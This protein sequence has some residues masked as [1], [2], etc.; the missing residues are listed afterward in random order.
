MQYRKIGQQDASIVAFGAWAI[1]GWMWGG[2]DEDDA[3]DAIHAAL[4]V[5]MN[6]IDTAPI[7]GFG[8]SEQVIGRAL[9]DKR[10]QAFI[11]TKCGMVWG[12]EFADKG[13]FKFNSDDQ[14]INPEGSTE[15]RIY[16]DP[17]S[18][19]RELEMSLDRLKTDYVDLYQTHWQESTTPIADT[20]AELE[21]M[22]S[23]GKI[24]TIGC[25]NATTDQMDQYRAAG[26]LDS[27]QEQYSML[28]R[29]LEASNLP[30]CQKHG[31]AF[32]AYSP[33]ARGLLTGKVTPDRQFDEGDQRAHMKRF[34]VDNRRRVQSMLQQIQ[35][36]AD[37]HGISLTQLAIAWT[38]AQP[39]CS[40]VLCGARNRQQVSEN[41]GAGDVNLSDEQIQRINN[42]I[43]EYEA[44]VV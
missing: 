27:D 43:A 11:A 3:V 10:D 22:R 17:K 14:R 42:A 21:K 41:A 18:I 32:L 4:D 37:E 31:I 44:A 7:Y 24:R 36:V 28:D 33:L 40:H 9:R 2:A 19:R 30:Y 29:D 16:L 5:G 20:M 34:S 8:A 6:F 35:P 26:R 1:G 13:E 38:A 39:G 12:P 15:V 23:E 25:S